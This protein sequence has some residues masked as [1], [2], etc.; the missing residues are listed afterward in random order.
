[1]WPPQAKEDLVGGEVGAAAEGWAALAEV[2]AV[3]SDRAAVAA[4]G[5]LA[6]EVDPVEAVAVGSVEAVVAE[7]SVA[8]VAAGVVEP[9]AGPAIALQV[10]RI[11]GNFTEQYTNSGFDA[12]PY[13]LNVAESPQIPSYRE[14][15][16]FSLGGPLV[17]PHVYRGGNKTS[18]FAS[19]NLQ[20]GRTGLDSFSTVP[21]AAERLG[22]FSDTVIA[23]GPYAG[24]VPT[25]YDPLSSATGARTAFAGNAIPT[26]RLDSAATGLL[27]YIPLPNLPGVVQNFHLQVP[28]PSSNDRVMGRIGQQIN[29]KNSLNVMYYFNSSRS[30]SVGNVPELS[31]H[32]TVRGQNLSV[33]ESHTFNSAPRQHLHVEF[34]S[35]DA[36][37]R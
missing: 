29:S 2:P 13:P 33:G 30:R 21:T 25:I 1:M 16:G 4:A 34:Q 11:R 17:I 14:T 7:D 12:H 26:L 31:S 37:R 10:N 23:S 6:G 15:F 22:S 36:P 3:D 5:R 20:R 18:W 24:T 27:Q 28:L 9:A 32:T 8:V 35:P 19:Y